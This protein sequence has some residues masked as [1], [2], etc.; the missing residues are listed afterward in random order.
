MKIRK[1]YIVVELEDEDEV[2]PKTFRMCLGQ[3]HHFDQQYW[4]KTKKEVNKDGLIVHY[5][6]ILKDSNE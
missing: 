3:A 2:G 4:G 6:Q 1:D 5:Y